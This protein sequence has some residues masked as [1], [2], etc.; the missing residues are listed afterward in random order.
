MMGLLQSNTLILQQWCVLRTTPSIIL[1]ELTDALIHQST[2]G[3]IKQSVTVTQ[4][5]PH[6]CGV[7]VVGMIALQLTGRHLHE[8]QRPFQARKRQ[9]HR[10]L[11]HSSAQQVHDACAQHTQ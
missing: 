2:N 11:A 9:V 5:K 1:S 6:L 8:C 4:S 3:P 10:L 7:G